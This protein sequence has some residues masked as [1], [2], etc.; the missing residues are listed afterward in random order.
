MIVDHSMAS[1]DDRQLGCETGVPKLESHASPKSQVSNTKLILA[2][3]ML[4]RE[5]AGHHLC[6]WH[7]YDTGGGRTLSLSDVGWWQPLRR[8]L[9]TL[10]ISARKTLGAMELEG[11]LCAILWLIVQRAWKKMKMANVY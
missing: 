11:C 8:E 6:I 5:V 9:D 10:E 1:N 4:F 7:Y 3:F 2:N